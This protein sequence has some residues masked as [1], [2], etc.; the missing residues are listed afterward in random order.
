MKPIALKKIRV[1]TA[2]TISGTMIGRLMSAKLTDFP[3]NAPPRT[4]PTA[5]EVAMTVDVTAAMAAIDNEFQAAS[6]NF[7]ASRPKKTSSYH[8]RLSPPQIVID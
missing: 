1:A 7:P 5:A 8:R 3:R 4:I 6:L 2:V